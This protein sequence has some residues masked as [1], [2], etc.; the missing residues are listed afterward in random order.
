MQ[1]FERYNLVQFH[2]PETGR[3]AS[4][5][6]QLHVLLAIQFEVTVFQAPEQWIF[7]GVAHRTPDTEPIFVR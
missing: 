6:S 7:G 2:W 3:I 4:R 1:E 5:E